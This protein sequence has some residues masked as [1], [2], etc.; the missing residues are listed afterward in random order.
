MSTIA[1][2][3][4]LEGQVLHALLADLSVAD[5]ARPTTFKNWT[6]NKVVSICTARIWRQSS[7]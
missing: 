1:E 4:L 2:D 5:W 3:F 7:R 6:I